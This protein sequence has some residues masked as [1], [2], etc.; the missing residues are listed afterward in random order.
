MERPARVLGVQLTSVRGGK[1]YRLSGWNKQLTN[2]LDPESYIYL[3]NNCI[4]PA[5]RQI[6]IKCSGLPLK[7]HSLAI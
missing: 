6:R 4:S 1:F 2:A 7:E 5:V 3:I